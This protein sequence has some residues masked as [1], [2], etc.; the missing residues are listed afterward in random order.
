[1]HDLFR[2]LASLII[3]N[4]FQGSSHQLRTAWGLGALLPVGGAAGG[5][6]LEH[7]SA[8]TKQA[9]LK[10]AHI[11]ARP[12]QGK[13]MEFNSI[14]QN[15]DRVFVDFPEIAL[16]NRVGPCCALMAK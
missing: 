16:G 4:P 2:S 11:W 8:Q 6:T 7:C 15:M 3:H 13:F 9:Y 1:M 14:N 12:L 5:P 10:K